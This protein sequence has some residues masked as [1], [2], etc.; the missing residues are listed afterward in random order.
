MLWSL[1]CKGYPAWKIQLVH[2]LYS[3]VPL[4][5]DEALVLFI[6]LWVL[7]VLHKLG[8]L[9][10]TLKCLAAVHLVLFRLS[11]IHPFLHP[12]LAS[13]LLNAW[14]LYLRLILPF[15]IDPGSVGIVLVPFLPVV[16][17]VAVVLGSGL[18]VGV[19]LGLW[20]RLPFGLSLLLSFGLPLRFSLRL[21]SIF[22]ARLPAFVFV[23]GSAR[24][25]WVDK[26]QIW[27]QLDLNP[28]YSFWRN[29]NYHK[30]PPLK[31]V[32]RYWTNDISLSILSLESNSFPWY[33]L[34]EGHN[35]FVMDLI[36][37]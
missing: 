28:F 7:K 12:L 26:N 6:L 34:F 24:S 18:L 1:R 19:L 22:L 2:L 15:F 29:I 20:F 11:L 5:R 31:A 36:L 33:K 17:V 4:V 13:I 35:V 21:L 25:H 16:V 8:F 23:F 10:V 14:S 9:V 3:V 27:N 32:I 30:K 37:P